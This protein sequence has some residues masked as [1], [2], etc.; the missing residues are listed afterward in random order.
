MII[1]IITSAQSICN[2]IEYVITFILM[3]QLKIKW[4]LNI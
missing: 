1:P 4:V 3:I 2:K